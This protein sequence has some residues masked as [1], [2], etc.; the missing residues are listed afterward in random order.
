M[1]SAL[2][3]GTER[4][5]RT[6]NDIKVCKIMTGVRTIMRLGWVFFVTPRM[7]GTQ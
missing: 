5:W 2:E 4:E 1:S 6:E 7:V 3:R